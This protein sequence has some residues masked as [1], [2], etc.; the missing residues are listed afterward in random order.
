ME[1]SML[2]A[3]LS[4]PSRFARPRVDVAAAFRAW[5]MANGHVAHTHC[6]GCAAYYPAPA[7][8]E[9]LTEPPIPPKK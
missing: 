5:L 4:G 3:A 8:T 9:G 2:S 6:A 1:A 7:A